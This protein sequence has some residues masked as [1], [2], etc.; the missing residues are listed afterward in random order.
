MSTKKVYAL[1]FIVFIALLDL[2]SFVNYDLSQWNGNH[3]VS[4]D[5]AFDFFSY[6]ICSG[7]IN[8]DGISDLICSA[9]FSDFQGRNSAGAVYIFF[10]NESIPNYEYINLSI[11]NAD[12]TIVGAENNDQLGKS[13]DSGLIDSDIYSDL[14]IGAPYAGTDILDQTGK[15][16]VIKGSNQLPSL[17]DLAEYETQTF[18]GSSQNDLI[19]SSLILTDINNDSQSEIIIGAP[20]A[21]S[22]VANNC[23]KTYILWSNSTYP[24]Q[25][26]INELDNIT[27]FLGLNSNDNSSFSFS[28]GN[29]NNDLF[30]DLLV[31]APGYDN[32]IYNN[33]G[34]IYV[35]YGRTSMP[36]QEISLGNSNYVNLTIKA[37]EQNS[38]F[39]NSM[40][41]GDYNHDNNDDLV[42]TDFSTDLERG[43]IYLLFGSNSLPSSIELNQNNANM[44][45]T[46][47]ETDDNF[48]STLLIK[49]L[50]GDQIQDLIIGTSGATTINGIGSGKVD[51]LYGQDNPPININ[52]E[53][54]N[55]DMRIIGNSVDDRLGSDFVVHDFNNDDKMDITIAAP[56][57]YNNFGSATT[58]LGGIPYF[59]NPT[60]SNGASDVDIAQP[61]SFSL[62]D[63][64]EIDINSIRVVIAGTIYDINS[65]NLT[66]SGALNSYRIAINPEEF[67]GYNQVIDVSVVANDNDGF[68]IPTTAYRFFT[69][70]DTDPPYTST[71]NPAP[72]DTDVSVDTNISFHILDLGEGV[73]LSTIKVNIDGNIYTQ[74]DSEF[75]YYGTP[76]DYF[77]E[78]NPSA[79]FAYEQTVNVLISASD[80]AESP[81]A[82][83]TFAYSFQ[84]LED[85]SSP[86][87]LYIDPTYEEVIARNHPVTI[88]IVDYESGLNIDS[89][90][91]ELDNNSIINET[92]IIPIQSDKGIRLSWNPMPD[93]IFEIGEHLIHFYIE[94]RS[95]LKNSI[96]TL[97]VFTVEADLEPP[98]TMNHH[99]EKFSMDNPENTSFSVD[100]IDT[101]SGID[102][103]T[104]SIRINGVEIIGLNSTKVDEITNGYRISHTPENYYSNIVTVQINAS[105]Y[106]IPANVMNMEEYTFTC[107]QDLGTPYISST[108]PADQELNVLPNTDIT[109]S[110]KDELTGVNPKSVRLYINENDITEYIIVNETIEQVDVLYTSSVNF[111]FNQWV[112]V[113]VICEDLAS[114]PNSMDTSYSFR[115]I[116]DIEPPFLS[117]LHPENNDIGVPATENVSFEI[118]DSGLGVDI[119]SLVIHENNVEIIPVTEQ[120]ENESNYRITW[121]HEPYEY[122][123]TVTIVVSVSDL[124]PI[125]NSLSNYNFSFVVADD[126]M[127]P[128]YFESFNPAQQS[129]GIPIDTS[130]SFR[131]MDTETGV[132]PNSILFNINNQQIEDYLI[133]EVIENEA[134]GYSI[135]YTP[136]SKFNYNQTVN[137]QIY[138]ID[139]SS[140]HNEASINYHFTTINDIDPP[141]LVMSNPA[142]GEFGYPFSLIYLHFYD[143]LS[144]V[145]PNN[146][147]F[148][149]NSTPI[150]D[151]YTELSDNGCKIRYITDDL[152][153]AETVEVSYSIADNIGNLLE[154]KY[155][156]N[157][158]E[159]EFEPYF[160]LK[161]PESEIKINESLEIA[162]LDKGTGIDSTSI[163]LKINN[164]D[165]NSF[166]LDN[167]TYNSN[168]DSL[169]YLLTYII[170]NYYYEGQ[171][172]SI[173]IAAHD[174][175]KPEPLGA[176]AQF[177]IN[178]FKNT[179]IDRVTVI[180]DIITPNWDGYNDQARIIIPVDSQNDK[181]DCIVF[182]R[183]G[184]KVKKL[185][186]STYNYINPETNQTYNCK[187]AVW[188]GV[189]QSGK[190][191]S[192]GIYLCQ[193]KVNGKVHLNTI[194]VAK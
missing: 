23:G 140:N 178:I 161:Y 8:G 102:L 150:F 143:D 101:L 185:S 149:I 32:G 84:C 72:G 4:G 115:V 25:S 55:P 168:P 100:I 34:A 64:E 26:T 184:K 87:I 138:A 118:H 192:P 71:W 11:S 68:T 12:V 152:N 175:S 37:R 43:R 98:Y 119:N 165:I 162:I 128:P 124:A 129:I 44:V 158:I 163:S 76:N 53:D 61:V 111:D 28:S 126:D 109:L 74:D 24:Q 78:I 91:L 31:S 15:V 179:D 171:Q 69:R 83:S 70:Q 120:I 131:I 169:G 7:D 112:T 21:D 125:P 5:T 155:S 13:I 47:E 3:C 176:E 94:D 46:A 45:I 191:V 117:N 182:N 147:S 85:I 154:D 104:V 132:N 77:I 153:G 190:L 193:V 116:P 22:N 166:N 122:G 174:K 18:I 187:S 167:S 79:N 133:E 170:D 75:S 16:Y 159:D 189:N 90:I 160:I 106:N 52:I 82:M 2:D 65:P 89:L 97:S 14:V 17:I 51:I 93:N 48:G 50:S 188:E 10:G 38:R 156:F 27:V 139:N 80:F 54:S 29:I 57:G 67:F 39:G 92:E 63:D 136:E 172:L 1:I 113:R 114:V 81:N 146:I 137:I 108:S 127:I 42:I 123:E 157:L 121:N 177:S 58:I 135:L 60:P 99:P 180:P 6:D 144:G 183:S 62:T 59:S 103:E 148:N 36:Y 141:Y 164:R 96:D 173:D 181:V 33:S 194:T 151:F 49:D 41:C 145:N 95:A 186:C 19:G 105:D 9:P 88:E 20:T 56:Q 86:V 107:I 35:V 73:D 30:N 66:Y 130:I 142:E 40:A 134:T 110:L